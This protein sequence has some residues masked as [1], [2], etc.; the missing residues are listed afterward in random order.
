MQLRTVLSYA[1]DG[2]EFSPSRPGRFIHRER[3]RV[4]VDYEAGWCPSAGLH[5]AVEEKISCLDR[6]SMVCDFELPWSLTVVEG[7]TFC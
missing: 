5:S 3:T 1:V 2:G 7:Y 4:P 6:N